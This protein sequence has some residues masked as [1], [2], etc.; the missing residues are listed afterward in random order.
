MPPAVAQPKEDFTKGI[1]P[2]EEG[3]PTKERPNRKPL[4]EFL[5]LMKSYLMIKK[6]HQV[7]KF[8]I[9]AETGAIDANFDWDALSPEKLA[10]DQVARYTIYMQLSSET[11]NSVK[12]ILHAAPLFRRLEEV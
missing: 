12:H 3:A 7:L 8:D 1:D 10:Q 6:L 5:T 9:G 2:P 4:A 11:A